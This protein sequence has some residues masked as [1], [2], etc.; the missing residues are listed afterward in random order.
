M[1]IFLTL[2]RWA[3]VEIIFFK[4]DNVS[5]CGQIQ[6]FIQI[7]FLYRYFQFQLGGLRV[8]VTDGC[9][10]NILRWL[11]SKIGLRC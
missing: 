7:A 3:N 9:V 10:G 1:K 8:F 4:P 5:V 2:L 6:I 11:C